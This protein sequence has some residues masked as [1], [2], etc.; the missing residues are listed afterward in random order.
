[1][2]FHKSVENAR[3]IH[4]LWHVKYAHTNA[5]KI[6]AH[7]CRVWKR[8]EDREPASPVDGEEQESEHYKELRKI[9]Q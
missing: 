3:F 6:N 9:C 7:L 2:T 1:M 8:T 5:S 4:I